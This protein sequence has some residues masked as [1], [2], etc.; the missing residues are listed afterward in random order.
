LILDYS[1]WIPIGKTAAP[2]LYCTD[3]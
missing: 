1:S 2:K 3:F